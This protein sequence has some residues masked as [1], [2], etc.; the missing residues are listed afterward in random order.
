[1][2]RM[3][4]RR[5]GKSSSTRPYHTSTPDWVPLKAAEIEEIV[6]KLGKEGTSTSEIGRRLRDQYSVPSVKLCTG[7]KITKILQDNNVEFKLPEDLSNLLRKVYNLDAHMR[8]NPKDLHNQRAMKLLEEKIRRL[9]RYYKNNDLLPGDWKY[10]IS[11]VKL[12]LE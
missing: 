8:S 1:M 9:V 7:K 2:A 11:A 5:K 6:V 12:L 3:H 4:A 10:S